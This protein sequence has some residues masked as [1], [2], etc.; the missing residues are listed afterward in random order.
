MPQTFII[1]FFN[2]HLGYSLYFTVVCLCHNMYNHLVS[3]KGYQT[4]CRDIT[5]LNY[6][7]TDNKTYCYNLNLLN[8]VKILFHSR[9]I[10]FIFNH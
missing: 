3:K 10:F 1:F 5:N 4:V 6:S 7:K 2:I 9:V 8:S